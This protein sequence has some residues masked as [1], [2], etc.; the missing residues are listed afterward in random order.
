MITFIRAFTAP[1]ISLVFMILGNGLFNTFIPVRLEM[2]LYNKETIGLVTSSLYVGIL[3]GSL[4]MDR[5]ITKKGYIRSFLYFSACSSILILC[6]ALWINPYYWAILRLCAGI[7]MAGI[8]TIIESWILAIAPPHLRSAIL[9]TYL[10]IFYGTL[11]ISQLLL[12]LTNPLSLKPFLIASFCFALSL[13]PFFFTKLTEPKLQPAPRLK[14]KEL[15]Q[16]SPLGFL[17]GIVS[18]IILASIYGLVPIYAKEVGMSIS[19]ISNLMALLIL[20]GLTFQW[21]FGKLADKHNRKNILIIASLLTA[22]TALAI[23][24][25]N[26]EIPL[27]LF[28][29]AFLFGGFSFTIYPLSI[30]YVSEKLKNEQIVSASA[31]F[32]LFYGIGAISSPMIASWIMNLLGSSSLFH[33]LAAAALLLCLSGLIKKAAAKTMEEKEKTDASSPCNEE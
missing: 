31:G 14:A 22:I 19:E 6:Q 7:C 29:L 17:G 4:K 23:S 24:I 27:L 2:E 25:F 18:G 15:F 9:A 5:W 10:A 8:L 32:I 30:A 20:G 12:N 3:L 21:P 1:F 13:I 16:L 33:F 11:S 26:H 28:A